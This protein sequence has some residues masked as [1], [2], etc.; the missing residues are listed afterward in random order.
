[1]VE[2]ALNILE[3]SNLFI[4]GGAG[5]GKT[6]LTRALIDDA[7]QKGKSVARLASTGMA[8][9]LIGGQT[10]H[11]FFDL[12]IAS[13]QEELERNGKLDPS[14][15]IIKLI[16]S[17]QIIVID[18]ISMVG[19]PLLDMIR[20]R[21][22]QAE[23]SGRLIVVGDFLQLPPVTRGSEP[24][25]FA[26]E[27]PSWERFGFETIHL[28]GSYRTHEAEFLNLLEQ[29]R[30][31]RIDEEAMGALDA[32]VRELNKDMSTITLLFGKN[33]SAQNHNR[34]QLE[35]L[36]G[37]IIELSTYVTVHDKK[38]QD[39]DIERFMS[40]SRIEPVLALKV[41]APILFTRNAWNYYNGE[42]GRIT[43]IEEDVIWIKKADGVNVKVERVDTTKT[44]W[45]E[46]GNSASE[47]KL[48]TL[49]QFPITLAFAITIHKSQGM[50][51]ADYVIETNEIFAPSQFYVALSR[52]VS[53]HRVTLIRPNRGWEKLC[54][55]HP[56]AKRFIDLM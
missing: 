55:V 21:L 36:H 5:S 20:L 50:S 43:S 14:K 18:E 9:T 40:E 3:T 1:M 35:H 56:K 15:K 49:S 54:F 30:H 13:T 26:F 42:R 10:L 4:T 28:E 17:M 19:A 7:V 6:T 39:R 46:K 2:N 23:F 25:Y 8:A 33:I 29:V 32:L 47:E 27:S 12:G 53:A 41:G 31:A 16:R 45:V 38:M 37:E 52:S 51:L 11:S 22:L 24:I 34:S 44:R 48:I